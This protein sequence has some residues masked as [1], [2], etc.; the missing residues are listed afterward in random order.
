MMFATTNQNNRELQK[1][2]QQIENGRYAIDTVTQ[3]LRLAGFYGHIDD[4][5]NIA[6]PATIPPDPC[7]ASNTAN[8]L[9]SLWYPVQGYAGTV[10][11]ATPASDARPDVSTTSCAALTNANLR[12]GSDVL[13]VRRVDTNALLATDVTVSNGFY[14]QASSKNMDL[15]LGAGTALGLCGGG[16]PVE[17]CKANGGASVLK[18]NNGATPAPS[19]PIRKLHVDIYFVAPCSSGSD[20]VGG[21]SG[22]CKAG[23]DTIPTLKRLELFTSGTMRIVPL[24]EGVDLFKV[25]YGV[26]TL[27]STTNVATGY[28][29]DSAVDSYTAT[30]AD[31][32]TVIAAKI[33]VLARNTEQTTGY[34][35]TKTYTLGTISVPARNDAFKRHAFVSAV[36]IVNIAGRREIPQ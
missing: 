16:A 29:G 13:V 23:D 9:S 6:A 27:P 25:L 10:D 17:L 26:D 4:L 5:S 7:E 11:P 33:Y 32:Q 2:S 3:D 31:F 22:V 1:T 18:Y 15:Q 19:S 12:P 14:I 35:D 34:V 20:T 30:P 24:V 28:K 21:I 36:R 8:I